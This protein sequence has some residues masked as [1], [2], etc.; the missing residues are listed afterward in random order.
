MSRA[1]LLSLLLLIERC[2]SQLC[3]MPG[4][5][6]ATDCAGTM[7]A[8]RYVAESPAYKG[9]KLK[10][11]DLIGRCRA[12]HIATEGKPNLLGRVVKVKNH[13]GDADVTTGRIGR[14]DLLDNAAVDW[15]AATAALEASPDGSEVSCV[16][17]FDMRPPRYASIC[18][19]S[20]AF[21][22]LWA[23][24]T[25]FN[26]ARPTTATSAW[27]YRTS[28]LTVDTGPDAPDAGRAGLSAGLKGRMPPLACAPET[29]ASSCF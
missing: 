6:I 7:H 1:E 23:R 15:C 24:P 8:A 20:Y 5:A 9:Q 14:G 4:V 29:E 28:S 10:N 17:R 12:R 2:G 21:A 11:M 25:I 19:E 27:R 3:R 18:S 16:L 13:V 22:P 26:A